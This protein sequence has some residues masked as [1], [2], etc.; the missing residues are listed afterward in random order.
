MGR[1]GVVSN[2][3][4]DGPTVAGSTPS[5]QEAVAD[6]SRAARYGPTKHGSRRSPAIIAVVLVEAYLDRDVRL[7]LAGS[8]TFSLSVV[9][10][11]SVRLS[12][13]GATAD[14]GGGGNGRAVRLPRRASGEDLFPWRS[15]L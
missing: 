12:R 11:G 3:H 2:P 6:V 13:S 9:L 4:I 14:R 8:T 1:Q 5:W 15:L 7:D 10:E